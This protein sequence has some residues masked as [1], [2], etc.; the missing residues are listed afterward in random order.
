MIATVVV[1]VVFLGLG[2]SVLGL[3]MRS[4]RRGKAKG[5]T[6]AG[7]RAT[8]LSTGLVVLGLGV[9]VPVLLL[10]YNASSESKAATGGLKLTTA[11]ESG[12]RLF[13]RNCSTC[14]TLAAANAVG[15]VGP[16]LDDII[17]PISGKAQRVAFIL[18]AV[19]NGRARGNGQMPRAIVDGNDAKDVADFVATVAGR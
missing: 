13:A 11:Q 3:A 16:I 19:N 5:P 17:P 15:K 7:Q 2:L 1:V 10:V 14:H 18:D 6:R 12:R 8:L 4:G 9:A